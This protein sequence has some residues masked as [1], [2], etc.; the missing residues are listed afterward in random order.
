MIVKARAKMDNLS[1]LCV[2]ILIDKGI[3]D[4]DRTLCLS[5]ENKKGTNITH[6]SCSK[7]S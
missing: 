3:L 6:Q 4:I 7:K 5:K 2:F 1:M